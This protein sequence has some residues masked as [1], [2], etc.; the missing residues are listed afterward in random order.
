MIAL[1]SAAMSAPG[2]SKTLMCACGASPRTS[3]MSRAASPVWFAPG[4][5]P[6]ATEVR[7][8]LLALIPRQL[9]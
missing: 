5:I 3:S 2:A 8:T 4:L 1:Y 6:P 7:E 9:A